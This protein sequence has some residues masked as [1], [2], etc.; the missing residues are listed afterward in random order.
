MIVYFSGAFIPKEDVRIS[1]DD[2]GFTFA[3][4]VYEV[5]CAYNGQLFKLEEHLRRMERSLQALR[6]AGLDVSGLGEVVGEVLRRNDLERADA[7]LYL[8]VTRGVAP[9][10]HAFPDEVISPTVYASAVPYRLPEEKWAQG[11]RVI[12]VPDLRWSRCDVKSV[13]LLPNVLASQQAKEAGA[14]EALFVRE[15][16]ITEG[17]H[18]SF[19]GV[20]DGML[21]T[22]P[23]NNRILTGITRG[24]V[25]DLCRELGIPF[26][27]SP[28]GEGDLHRASELMVL[29]TTTGIMPVVTVDDWPVGDGRPGP[30]TRR[31]QR[32]FREMA[33]RRMAIL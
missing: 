21:V 18:T 4:G 11:V 3:D 7:K 9:R 16:V 2:R 23:L 15:G 31:L 1:P 29:G 24:I 20:F 26:Q 25:L 8:Q 19:C 10:R 30:T 22:H 12:L 5:I 14:Y 6:I 27:E 17:S 32:A 28:I 33:I 13:A